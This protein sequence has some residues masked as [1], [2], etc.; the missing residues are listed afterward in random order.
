MRFLLD[1]NLSRNWV[2]LRDSGYD[3]THDAELGLLAAS[4]EEIPD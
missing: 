3:A 2:R 1:A 4:D